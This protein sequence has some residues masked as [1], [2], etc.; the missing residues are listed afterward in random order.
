MPRPTTGDVDGP[1]HRRLD[2]TAG[3]W[4]ERFGGRRFTTA[5]IDFRRD[6]A[7]ANEVIARLV[8]PMRVVRGRLLEHQRTN[9]EAFDGVELISFLPSLEG[10]HDIHP[11]LP[12]R[13]GP[14][15]KPLD[16]FSQATHE[17]RHPLE[18]PWATSIRVI[19]GGSP[20]ALLIVGPDDDGGRMGRGVG[21]CIRAQPIARLH[22][23]D[24]DD[25]PMDRIRAGRRARTARR[26][27]AR[28]AGS[29]WTTS[30]RARPARRSSSAPGGRHRGA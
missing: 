13:V 21:K 5:K 25:P 23:G 6:L 18:A 26:R 20:P 24:G 17:D 28:T 11:G 1:D 4:P 30:S 15:D 7:A 10:V 19:N 27:P 8:G 3:A 2:S 12:D 16:S 29:G 14:V 22:E 9:V